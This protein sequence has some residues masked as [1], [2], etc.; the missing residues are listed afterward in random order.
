MTYVLAFLAAITGTAFGFFAGMMLG[1]AVAALI[2]ISSFEGEAGYFAAF[3]FGPLG[4]VI[5]LGLGLWLVFRYYGG[6]R[7][8][9]AIASRSALVLVAIAV[10]GVAGIQIR[11]ATVD[12]NNG[13]APQLDYEIRLPANAKV[14]ERLTFDVEMQ[15]GTQ[16][17][18]GFWHD[19]WLR[20]DLD[21]PVLIGFVPLYTRTSQRILVL[22]RAGEPKLLFNIRLPATPSASDTYG[23]WQRVDFI[24]DTKADSTRRAPTAAENF[25]IRYRV[26]KPND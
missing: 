24:D 23:A 4:G 26:P 7:G 1:G 8:F 14:G 18:G 21:R 20:Y 3:I 15:A 10:V 9:S 22:S 19:P 25:E 2:G 16:R 5:G 12:F 11:L 17:S 6:Y 13:P